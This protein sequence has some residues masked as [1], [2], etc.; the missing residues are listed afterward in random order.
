MGLILLNVIWPY[1][2]EMQSH[3]CSSGVS[4][5]RIHMGMELTR[6][7]VGDDDALFKVF[8]HHNDAIVCCAWKVSSQS[9]GILQI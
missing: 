1:V 5:C 6:V 9:L 4:G 8:W 7:D 3:F 2:L